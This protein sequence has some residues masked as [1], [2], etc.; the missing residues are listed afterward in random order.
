MVQRIRG[1]LW[2]FRHLLIALAAVASLLS[3]LQVIGGL[4]PSTQQ[5]VVTSVPLA[6]GTVLEEGHLTITDVPAELV[7]HGSMTSL[8]E[9]L[10]EVLVSALPQGMP[11]PDSML[12]TSKFLDLAPDG[13]AI[14]PVTIVADGT[15][16]LATSG[17]SVSLYAPPSDF[18]ES[19]EAVELVQNAIVVGHG[20]IPE[21][22][23]FLSESENIRTVFLAIPQDTVTLVLGYGT[24]ATMRIVL[25]AA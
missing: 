24:G 18:D 1:I 19:A 3:I 23:R 12:L 10:G 6:A 16:G 13:Y 2:R 20:K 14:L 11:L 15:E 21:S 25:N 4:T 7:P 17:S 5:V 8:D 22:E 9:A